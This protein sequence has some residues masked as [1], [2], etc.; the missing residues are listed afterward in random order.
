LKTMGKI[1]HRDA[2]RQEEMDMVCAKVN[3]GVPA[4]N[5]RKSPRVLR[6]TVSCIAA[7]VA[8]GLAASLLLVA[9][10]ASVSTERSAAAVAGKKA[11][12]EAFPPYSGETKRVQIIRFGVPQEIA[13]QY[14]EL[15]EK[16]I[17]WGL[18]NTVIDEFSDTKRFQ[19]IEEK[20]AI[21]DRIMQ[22]WALSQSGIAVEEQQIDEKR[23]LSLPQYLVYAE[24]FEFSV[25]LSETVVGVAMKKVNTTQIG[26]Q[27]RLVDVS[28]GQYTPTSGTGEATTTEKTVWIT[29]DQPF[30]QSTVG[31]ATKRAVHAAVLALVKKM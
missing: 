21:R 14:P 10:C 18:Y 11:E 16:R 22:N 26:V 25:R 3:D 15:A 12:N 17:G 24:V 8:C 7:T 13:A 19:F 4:Q 27:L 30:D 5:I 2:Y 28:N 31:L 1:S 29:A 23:G 6:G 9:S 20:A